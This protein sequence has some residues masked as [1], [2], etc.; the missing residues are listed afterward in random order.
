MINF[1]Q[2]FS[3][4]ECCT[5]GVKFAISTDLKNNFKETKKTFYCPNGHGQA[6]VKSTAEILQ[7]KLD[8]TKRKLADRTN[9]IDEKDL[10]LGRLNRKIKRLSPKKK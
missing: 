9:E 5:C 4:E 6:Y 3:V 2:D 1:G 10:E 7:E 8:E